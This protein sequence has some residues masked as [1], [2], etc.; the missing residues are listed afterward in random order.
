MTPPDSAAL[1]PRKHLLEG[2]PIHLPARAVEVGEHLPDLK[3]TR[4]R[5]RPALLL[6]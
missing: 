6:L 5:K 1:D 4:L 2:G 3:T